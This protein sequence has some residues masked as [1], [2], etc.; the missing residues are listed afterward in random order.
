MTVHEFN[1]TIKSLKKLAH[2][3]QQASIF[4]FEEMHKYRRGSEDYNRCDS[5]SDM[6]GAKEYIIRKAIETITTIAETC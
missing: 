2:E 1:E 5:L 4:W 3:Y 6:Y